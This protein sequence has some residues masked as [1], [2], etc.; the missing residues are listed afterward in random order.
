M[1]LH[2]QGIKQA[3]EIVHSFVKI[4]KEIIKF[5]HQNASTLGLTV[6]QMGI[7]NSIYATPNTTLKDIS[8]RLSVPKSTMSVN[9]DELVNLGLIERKQSHEDRREIQLKVTTKGQ[10]MSKRSIENSTSYKAM[11]LAL[12]QL[13]EEDIQILL[14]IHNDLLNSLQHFK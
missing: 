7:L 12:E 1:I 14:R 10:E 13:S 3:S 9:V 8:E 5:T 11:E 6:Q 2:K 4:N